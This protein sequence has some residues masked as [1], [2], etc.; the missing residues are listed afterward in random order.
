MTTEL[1]P[2]VSDSDREA[3]LQVAH[4]A[5]RASAPRLWY[6]A[7]RQSSPLRN[8]ATWW[9]MREGGTA[10]AACLLYD[11]PFVTANGEAAQGYGFGS[12]ATRPGFRRRGL[13]SLLC[14]TV[15]ADAEG[16]CS[17][18]RSPRRSTSGSDTR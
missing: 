14:R 3:V 13:A 5:N 6:D 7:I 17:S 15:A 2:A 18:R 16:R 1:S 9:L 12:V 8:G 10:A 4:E 11:L